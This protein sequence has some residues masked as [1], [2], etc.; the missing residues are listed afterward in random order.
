MTSL[1][2][3]R[4]SG[5]FKSPPSLVVYVSNSKRLL[6]LYREKMP[7]AL[8]LRKVCEAILVGGS[9]VNVQLEVLCVP[10]EVP[11]CLLYRF[12]VMIFKPIQCLHMA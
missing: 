4:K 5:S 11:P 10:Q 6:H 3:S 12:M 1:T 2:T 9:C 8:Q 7:L